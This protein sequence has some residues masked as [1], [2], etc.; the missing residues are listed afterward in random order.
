MALART[1]TS[2]QRE[3]EKALYSTLHISA[4]SDNSLKCMETLATNSEKAALVRFLTIKYARDNINKNQ[5]LTTYLSKG[6][7]NMCSLFDL[8]VGA[9]LGDLRAVTAEMI[10][11]LGKILWS[12]CKIMIFFK[13]TILL[14]IQSRSFSITIFLLPLRSRHISNN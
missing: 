1:H 14:T 3:A 8:R 4:S 7:I 2:F 6:L 13:L 9:P 5:R 11:S 12:V 10:K